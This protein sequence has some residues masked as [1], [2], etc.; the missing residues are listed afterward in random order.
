[1]ERL[2]PPIDTYQAYGFYPDELEIGLPEPTPEPVLN[3]NGHS[4]P[5]FPKAPLIESIRELQVVNQHWREMVG[6]GDEDVESIVPRLVEEVGELHEALEHGVN[7][8]RAEVLSELADI[9]LYV[10]AMM[11]AMG[12]MADEVLT[13]KINRNVFK[14]NP[15]KVQDAMSNGMSQGEAMMKVKADWHRP[16][17]MQFFED[18]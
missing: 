11:N 16:N 4:P 17:D 5:E 13:A 8:N 6:I 14:Y 10:F 18:L 2:G 15:A 7:G 9:G 1:M 3:G 12:A